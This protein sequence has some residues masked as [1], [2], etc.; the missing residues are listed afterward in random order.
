MKMSFINHVESWRGRGVCQMTI[1][2][3]KPYLLKLTTNMGGR[4][5]QKYLKIWP[6]GLWMAPKGPLYGRCHDEWS[7]FCKLLNPMCHYRVAAQLKRKKSRP[8]TRSILYISSIFGQNSTTKYLW[9]FF[10]ISDFQMFTNCNGKVPHE[11]RE[12]NKCCLGVLFQNSIL[13]NEIRTL[14]TI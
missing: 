2:Y 12:L 7:Y 4:G 8:V 9:R 13:W 5:G 10:W 11:K 3:Y 6:R 1:L 14:Q